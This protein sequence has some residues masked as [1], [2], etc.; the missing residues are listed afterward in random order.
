MA[1]SRNH[2]ANTPVI[3]QPV[4]RGRGLPCLP[5]PPPPSPP[6]APQ[7][8]LM[9]RLIQNYSPMAPSILSNNPRG[10]VE[11]IMDNIHQA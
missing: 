11:G 6:P 1:K 5:P 7:K 2:S 10:E 4:L 8:S 3:Q 9:L